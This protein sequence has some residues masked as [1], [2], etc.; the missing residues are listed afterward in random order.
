MHDSQWVTKL[1]KDCRLHK[2]LRS[3][4]YSSQLLSY[5]LCMWRLGRRALRRRVRISRRPAVVHVHGCLVST[6][7][8][9]MIVVYWTGKVTTFQD[10]ILGSLSKRGGDSHRL[11]GSSCLNPLRIRL[12]V[13]VLR[14]ARSL[15]NVSL[16]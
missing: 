15:T 8:L 9:G 6:H 7:S 10:K 5:L 4:L 13:V 12:S 16:R 3:Q 14:V 2:C 1:V 11:R